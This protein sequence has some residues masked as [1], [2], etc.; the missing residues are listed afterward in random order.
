[1]KNS[2]QNA[3]TEG[4]IWKALILFCLPIMAGTLFQQLYNAVD[5]IV[6]G[7]FCGTQALASVGGSSGMIVQLMVGFSVGITSGVTVIA[8]R[9][10]G[11]GE[12]EKLR[13]SVHTSMALALAGGIAIGILGWACTPFFLNLLGTPEELLDGS[14]LYLQIYFSGFVFVMIYNIGSSLLR[15]M[16]DSKSPLYYLMACCCVNVVLDVLLVVFFR[17]GIA[18]V[19]IATVTAQAVSAILVFRKLM[20][21]EDSCRMEIR[22]IRF[23][24][25]VLLSILAIGIPAGIQSLMN[26]VSGMIMTSAV[27]GLGTYAVAGNT[28]YA[29][30][31]G[32]YW[33][34]SSGFT[35][36]VATFVGQN[37]GAGLYPRMR[38]CIKVAMGVYLG[39]SIAVS[40]IFWFGSS[41]MLLMFTSDPLVLEQAM[42]VMKAIAPFYAIV[43]VYEVIIS[44]F[45][46]VKVVVLPTIIN[47]LGLCGVRAAWVLWVG[48]HAQ[49]VYD[50]II[51]C[52]ISWAFT[53]V[54][55]LVMFL[56]IGKKAFYENPSQG[57]L[58]TV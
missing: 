17:M 53:A 14:K 8:A 39:I 2:K 42:L 25:P 32:I 30:L 51:S 19:A 36:A 37:A 5:V 6:I 58:T 22:K 40:G 41:T 4:V 9:H 13:Q 50:I 23:T 45:R 52:P 34:I 27:N 38:Q 12:W 10:Y 20:R 11:A 55:T 54:C 33:M 26:S 24:L 16:G 28:A 3:I 15:A 49:S 18:G 44:A 47:V 29:K 1:M 31:D 21:L 43:P 7:R 57:E 56:A 35:V 48:S 46:G